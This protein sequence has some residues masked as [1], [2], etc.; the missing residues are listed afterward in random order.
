LR[1][2]EVLILGSGNVVHN[3]HTYAWGRHPAQPFNWA[4]RFEAR[5][6][7]LIE[8]HDYGAL[9]DYAALGRDAELSLP[10]PEHYL[11]P[12]LR[13]GRQR[14]GRRRELSSRRH[15]RRLDLDAVNPI[16]VRPEV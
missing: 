10:T 16:R 3:L 6:R 4:A 7:N 13:A 5:V 14:G 2:E 12:A 1:D 11:P 15:G 9:V 8:N